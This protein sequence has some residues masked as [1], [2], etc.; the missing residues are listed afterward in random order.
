MG[1]S[2]CREIIL[3]QGGKVDIKSEIG[4]GT[5]FIINLKARCIVNVDQ[6]RQAVL[7]F[8]KF[9]QTQTVNSSIVNEEIKEVKESDES[10]CSSDNSSDEDDFEEAQSWNRG[11]SS[12]GRQNRSEMASESFNMSGK[13]LYTISE[14]S[15]ECIPELPQPNERRCLLANDN[16]FLLLAF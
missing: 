15:A 4:K 5:E 6:Q 12:R 2:I 14:K 16:S 7:N 9:G 10:S 1:L 11:G 8:E 13:S 3:A